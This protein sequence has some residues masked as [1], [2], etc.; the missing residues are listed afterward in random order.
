MGRKPDQVREMG[1]ARWPA[2]LRG[3]DG[4]NNV[5]S[6]MDLTETDLTTAGC[7]MACEENMARKRTKNSK[8]CATSRG[9]LLL[10]TSFKGSD[11]ISFCGIVLSE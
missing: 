11:G 7:A 4:K 6:R 10:K 5:P 8:E 3:G 9:R 2:I 1:G